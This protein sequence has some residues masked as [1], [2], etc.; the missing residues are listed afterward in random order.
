MPLFLHDR[1]CSLL[2]GAGPAQE[3]DDDE[4]YAAAPQIAV[5]SLV[6][7]RFQRDVQKCTPRDEEFEWWEGGAVQT[8]AT[9]PL[10]R[11]YSAAKERFAENAPN[12][13]RLQ[14]VC[15][16]FT[17]D[18]PL[19]KLSFIHDAGRPPLVNH[20]DDDQA[21]EKGYGVSRRLLFKVAEPR[22][23]KLCDWWSECS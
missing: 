19:H 8:L 21:F 16:F 2:W 18:T 3:E 1:E 12:W 9:K 11:A 6:E 14:F 15:C 23:R 4:A 17:L 7:Q 22:Q 5:A 10:S 13:S 20:D